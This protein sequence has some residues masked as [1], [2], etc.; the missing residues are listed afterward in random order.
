MPPRAWQEGGSAP[1]GPL[2]GTEG[3]DSDATPERRPW[4][5]PP[6]RGLDPTV[7]VAVGAGEETGW[8]RSLT[9]ASRS[10]GLASPAQAVL[11]LRAHGALS[12][13]HILIL[14]AGTLELL[15]SSSLSTREALV[16]VTLTGDS[17]SATRGWGGGR[18]SWGDGWKDSGEW[19]L[20]RRTRVGLGSWVGGAERAGRHS[21][22]GRDG[23]GGQRRG[24]SSPSR[25]H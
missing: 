3:V 19:G 24:A 12:R 16:C 23:G 22:E 10:P 17:R 8:Q 7:H 13:G 6:V 11:L 1:R 2:P 5:P 25:R 18:E 4:C 21:G 9:V 20:T 15:C 14:L